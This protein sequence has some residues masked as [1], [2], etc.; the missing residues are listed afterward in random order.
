M[1][2]ALRIATNILVGKHDGD[3][4]TYISTMM[5]LAKALVKADRRIQEL[6]ATIVRQTHETPYPEELKD[7]IEQR[8]KLTSTIG[9][10]KAEVAELT[11]KW[12]HYT[13]PDP[14][15]DVAPLRA[16]FAADDTE[17]DHEAI[18]A[19]LV[20]AAA[21]IERLRARAV[22]CRDDCRRREEKIA[23][24]ESRIE[25]AHEVADVL[26]ERLG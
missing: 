11:R 12:E 15:Y 18:R 1:S 17:E 25:A 8:G 10:L 14:N 23:A 5:V 19:L 26:K 21:E 7:F 2:D 3:S 4:S 20:G 16:Y 22:M 6:L 24:L 13:Q 9:S